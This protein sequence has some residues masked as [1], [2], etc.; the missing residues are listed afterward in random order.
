[1][2]TAID[3]IKSPLKI[4]NIGLKSLGSDSAKYT[5]VTQLDWRP[6]AWAEPKLA[7]DL[8]FLYTDETEGSLGAKIDAANKLAFEN[9]TQAEPVII[10]IRPAIE[11]IEGMDDHTIMHAGPPIQWENMCGPM[12]GAVIGALLYEGLASTEEEAIEVASKDIKFASCND[13][14][15]VGPMAGIVSPHMP[16]FVAENK[17]DGMRAYVTMNEGWGRT[18]RFGAYDEAVIKRLHWMETTLSKAMKAVIDALG[19][20]NLK[21]LIAQAVQMGDECH[22]RDIA[23]TNLFFKMAAPCIFHSPNLTETEKGE[24]FDFL[25]KHEHFVLN[26]AM[27]SCKVSLLSASNIPYCTMVTA[28]ARNGY[29]VGIK[30]SGMGDQW[31]TAPAHVADGLF[32]PGYSAADA[33]PD[34][35][36]SAITETGGIGAFAMGTAPAIVQFVGGST[37]KAVKY[38]KDM[39]RITLGKHPVY[40]MPNLAFLG[41]PVGIDVRKACD[42]N[43]TPIINTGIAHKEAGHGLVGAGVVPAPS[44]CFQKALGAFADKYM[45]V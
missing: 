12:R 2:A 6:S 40:K 37:A 3:L 15:S 1:M 14:H 29:E 13:N 10:D 21:S 28:M 31:F 20:I 24:V 9:L 43:L 41:T 38:T 22:N 32:F 23:A 8:S 4:V 33:N 11:V 42:V 30:V 35:G 36:D 45:G 16:M 18:L 7:K 19:G 39:W 25:G 5:D 34:I 17:R 27:V 44:E 26:L